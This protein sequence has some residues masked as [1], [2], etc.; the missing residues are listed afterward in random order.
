MYLFLLQVLCKLWLLH[1]NQ[2]CHLIS[3][4]TNNK[5]V[6]LTPGFLISPA[7]N[8]NNRVF[9]APHLI[10]AQSAYKDIRIHS[11]H[12]SH[13]HT[14]TQ[15]CAPTH[16]HTHNKYMHYCWWIGKMRDQYAQAKGQVFSFHVHMKQIYVSLISAF[17]I[18]PV[19]TKRY[20][21]LTSGWWCHT[22][23]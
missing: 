6:N 17:P 4:H 14:H 15:T 2:M 10:R 9:M 19:H 5:S 20:A 18:I 22:F 12:H 21:T 16:P 7:N 23:K 13:T 1:I 8:N 3:S 11:F